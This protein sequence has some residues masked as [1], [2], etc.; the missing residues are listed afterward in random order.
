[1][2]AEIRVIGELAEDLRCGP[3]A[4]G[5]VGE[6]RPAAPVERTEDLE[7]VVGGGAPSAGGRFELDHGTVGGCRSAGVE[8][9]AGTVRGMG[10]VERLDPQQLR[11][12]RVVG[13]QRGVEDV[14]F[15][16]VAVGQ[17]VGSVRVGV[18]DPRVLATDAGRPA[19]GDPGGDPEDPGADDL[20]RHGVALV[21]PVV[22]G[23]ADR[24]GLRVGDLIVS[25]DGT[26]LTASRQEEAEE[27]TVLV[28]QY[29]PG[30]VVNIQILRGNESLD[31]PVTLELAPPAE[32]EMKRFRDD[33]LELVVRDMT[34]RDRVSRK[35]SDQVSGVVT[36]MVT[37]G[38][39]ADLGGLRAGDLIL[40]IDGAAVENVSVYENCVETA[41]KQ[42]RSRLVFKIRRGVHTR[43]IEIEPK[44]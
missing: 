37:G 28:R 15:V 8:D 13:P 27:L 16:V 11:D 5:Q 17:S 23:P 20:E 21:C 25:V 32:R 36:E 2:V 39:W 40:S 43:F 29:P 42:E 18:D 6:H 1:M 12:G 9:R 19:S 24:A 22:D 14:G 7:E 3:V 26:P 33:V 38:G 41:R 31:I 10:P 30:S 4:D 44:W 35:I 34:F